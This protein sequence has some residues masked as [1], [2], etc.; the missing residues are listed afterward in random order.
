VSG[1]LYV[2]AILP[3][4]APAV[5]DLGRDAIRGIDGGIVTGVEAAGLAAAVSAVDP[6]EFEAEPL[7]RLVRDMDW[8]APRAAAHQ[9]VNACLF[10]RTD[11]LIPLTFGTV[12]RTPVRI[13]AM[14]ETEGEVLTSCLDRVRDKAEWVLTLQRQTEEALAALEQQSDALR[15]VRARIATGAPGRAYLLSRQVETIRQRE[16]LTLDGRAVAALDELLPMAAETLPE[17][18]ETGPEEGPLARLSVLIDRSREADLLASIDA[19]RRH[20]ASRGYDL[21]PT[22]PWPPYRFSSRGAELLSAGR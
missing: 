7:N 18:L 20:W 16:L 19:Y 13:A 14:L 12:Y 4:G 15:D 1:L 6:S 22:G 10:D 8:L 17:R 5:V 11:A 2:Y 21:R 3:A 9:E